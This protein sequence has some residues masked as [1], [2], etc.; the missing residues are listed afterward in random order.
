MWYRTWNIV[1]ILIFILFFHID[2]LILRARSFK[3]KYFTPP[4]VTN[5]YLRSLSEVA[6]SMVPSYFTCYERKVDPVPKISNLQPRT[7]PN[8]VLRSKMQ[9]IPWEIPAYFLEIFYHNAL[10]KCYIDKDILFGIYRWNAVC[11]QCF[12]RIRRML[13]TAPLWQ[14]HI[15]SQS[16]AHI[17]VGLSF[18]CVWVTAVTTYDSTKLCW[19]NERFAS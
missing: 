3:S 2:N 8:I 7:S 16:L 13:K 4:R 17:K 1:R 12:H 18:K 14:G 19:N 6:R 15:C 9:V 11:V 5:T 10:S